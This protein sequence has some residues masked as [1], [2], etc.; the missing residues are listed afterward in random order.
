[1]TDWEARRA[2]ETELETTFLVE[3]AAGTGKTT[4]L[5]RRMVA[6]LREGKTRTDRLATVTFTR[7]ASAHLRE[8]FQLS[9][10]EALRAEADAENEKRLADALK[11]LDRCFIGTIHSFCGRLIRERPLEA[12]VDPGFEELEESEDSLF[13][14]ECWENYVERIYV[15]GDPL[16]EQLA[17]LGISL[18]ALKT[19]YEAVSNYPDVLLATSPVSRPNLDHVRKEV[20]RFLRSAQK[21]LPET[22]PD[23]GWDKLQSLLRRALR[24]ERVLDLDEDASLVRLLEVFDYAGTMTQ[25][26]WPD[27]RRAMDLKDRFDA[28]R[29][30]IVRPALYRWREYLHPILLNAIHPAAEDLRKRRLALGNLGFQDLLI[31]ARDLLRDHPE[32]RQ[33]L[34]RRFTHLLVDEFQDTDPI[35][36][37]IMLYLTSGAL[38][39]RDWRKLRPRPGALFVVG[40]PKQSIYRFRRADI[41]TYK[42][43]KEIMT[44]AGGCVLQLTTNFRAVGKICEWVNDAFSGFFPASNTRAQAAYTPLKASRA[45]G[46]KR[47]GVFRLELVSDGHRRADLIAQEDAARIARWI[48]WALDS[49]WQIVEEDETRENR[50]RDVEPADFMIILRNRLRLHHYGIALEGEGIPYEISG[51]RS[52]G[53]SEEIAALL[54]FLRALTD[55]DDPVAL[56]S[57]L[58]GALWGVDDNALYHFRRAG[59]RFSYLTEPPTIADER[60]GQAFSRLRE[61]RQWVRDLPP[62]AA[63]G[64]VCERLGIIA[65]SAALELGN[66]RSGNLLKALATGRMLSAEG[67]SFTAIVERLSRLAESADL[68]GMSVEPGRSDAVRL[69]NLHRAK[70]LEAPIVFLA[71]PNISPDR[72][73]LFFI[74][75]ET[76]QPEGHFLV[77]T[78]EGFRRRELARPIGWDAKASA[79]K[80]FQRAEEDRLLYVAATR[81]RN[82]LVVSVLRRRSKK[83]DR[84]RAYGPWATLSESIRQELPST[85]ASATIPPSVSFEELPG[86]MA[87]VRAQMRERH[88]VTARTS[89]GVAQVTQIAEVEGDHGSVLEDSGKGLAWGRLLH[90]LLESLMRDEALDV[91]SA[92]GSFIS[93]G[94]T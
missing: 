17:D 84:G 24:L 91:G 87:A 9:L 29:D 26:R 39:E 82:M 5:V 58:R 49:G 22:I 88:E 90:R 79:E 7:K 60:I 59:G 42:H 65:H 81:A 51:G 8:M 76:E 55:P 53:E 38:D 4:S 70:G 71:D 21:Q 93:S 44:Q 52:F 32:V 31:I 73:P 41:L 86:Q 92:R 68:E 2:V 40:D 63:L 11:G 48:R 54:P 28:L 35:Q 45:A 80:A 66:T 23:K 46:N 61:A 37:E 13:R 16:P 12:G 20:N 27:R 25:N 33:H 34:Q 64:R 83:T 69:M 67:H 18:D 75:R 47:S 77:V 62:G 89:Y 50:L 6:L 36:A 1:L 78:N 30:R 10:E 94:V 3:A 14:A 57:F 72:E 43:F 74:D 15:K 56:V 85:K 19:A